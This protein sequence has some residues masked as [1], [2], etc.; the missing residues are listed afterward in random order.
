MGAN[1]AREMLEAAKEENVRLEADNR[2]LTAKVEEHRIEIVRLR[3]VLMDMTIAAR[4]VEC[5]IPSPGVF[6]GHDHQC[7]CINQVGKA[8]DFHRCGCGEV[9]A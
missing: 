4:G 2:Y 9:W 3:G 6:P 7:I 1:D 5:G 8:H